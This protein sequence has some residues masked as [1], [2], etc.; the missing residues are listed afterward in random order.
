MFMQ[1]IADWLIA[2]GSMSVHNTR[3]LMN[4]VGALGTFACFIAVPLTANK[5]LIIGLLAVSQL[6]SSFTNSGVFS[7]VF[8]VAPRLAAVIMGIANGIGMTQGV[9]S[10]LLTAQ[11][12]GD[13][14]DDADS[15]SGSSSRNGP[16]HTGGWWKVW[17]VAAAL[18]LIAAVSF[19]YGSTGKNLESEWTRDESAE[20]SSGPS[21]VDARQRASI[22]DADRSESWR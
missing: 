3:R 20:G 9:L 8:D 16:A 1:L 21:R 12:V 6:F 17:A 7:N 14:D 10:P 4:G 5:H 19:H 22:Q 15:A 2:S 11:L 18:A 13:D